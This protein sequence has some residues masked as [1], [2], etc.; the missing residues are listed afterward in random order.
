MEMLRFNSLLKY[1]KIKKI[2]H[3][4]IFRPP[5]D[6]FWNN[7][8]NRSGGRL[9]WKRK[10]IWINIKRIKKNEAVYNLSDN[11]LIPKLIKKFNRKMNRGAKIINLL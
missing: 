7:W 2:P 4:L 11:R 3:V 9:K 10:K 6:A 1:L 5:I 8:K